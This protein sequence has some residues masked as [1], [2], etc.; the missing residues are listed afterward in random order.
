[1]AKVG[2]FIL[3]EKLRLEGEYEKASQ[4]YKDCVSLAIKTGSIKDELEARIKLEL[5]LWNLGQL[6][7]SE[8]YYLHAM[9]L[10]K[11]S[12]LKDREK[13]CRAALDIL[14]LYNEA[15][16]FRLKGSYEDSIEYFRKAILIAKNINSSDHELK[17]LRQ[18]SLC[19]WDQNS[20]QE[21]YNLNN[22]TL[23]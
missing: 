3:A 15:K 7:E 8:D 9:S 21:F 22:L 14:N 12:A 13:E 10:A 23:P 2:S 5:I 16:E 20:F 11:S 4:Y 19:Y 6:K 1:M 17:C 18:L